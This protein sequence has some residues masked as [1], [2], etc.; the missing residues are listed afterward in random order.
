M[1]QSKTELESNTENSFV[2]RQ[3]FFPMTLVLSLMMGPQLMG[4]SLMMGP[5]LIGLSLM[6]GPQLMGLILMMGPQLMGPQLM[7]LSLTTPIPTLT[8]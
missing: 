4:L 1:I 3:I 7:G 6:M 8:V 5:Q 2:S